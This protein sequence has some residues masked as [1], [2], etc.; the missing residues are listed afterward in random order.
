MRITIQE[1]FYYLLIAGFSYTIG[2][3]IGLLIF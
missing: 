2:W 1:A 3:I